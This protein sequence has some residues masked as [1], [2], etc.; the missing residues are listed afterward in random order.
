M[1]DLS[2]VDDT[3]ALLK[4]RLDM[5][6]NDLSGL[7]RDVSGSWAELEQA[8]LELDDVQLK[9][10]SVGCDSIC[11]E[12]DAIRLAQEWNVSRTKLLEADA[13][14]AL[15]AI[16]AEVMTDKA[17]AVEADPQLYN[18]REANAQ[19][20]IAALAAQELESHAEAAHKHQIRAMVMVAHE[21]RNPLSPIRT[22]AGLLSRARTDEL[23]HTRLQLIIERQV[24]HMSKLVD[25]LLDG[26]RISTGKLRLECSQIELAD[27]LNNAVETCSVAIASRGHQFTL[28]LPPTPLVIHGDPI[29]L[30]Q[31]FSNLLDNAAKYTP[32]GGILTL[33]V[34]VLESELRISVVDNGLGI[35]SEALPHV[36]DLF[37]QDSH[38]L[39]LHNGGL[40]IGLAVVRDL[41]ETHGGKVIARSAGKG[42]GSEFIVTLPLETAH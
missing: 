40:G 5:I 22:A 33:S 20:V 18:L 3:L 26:S 13:Q 15:A 38:A 10:N 21:L 17:V 34:S 7:Q 30:A 19:L 27:V 8:K 25:D 4:G 35:S 36:F 1:A 16:R 37:T 12:C 41:V 2:A 28:T 23:L 6:R 42:L 14:L 24:V 9:L 11:L 32:A 29:R 39:T 31:V